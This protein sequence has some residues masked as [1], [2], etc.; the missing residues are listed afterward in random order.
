[1][2]NI[3]RDFDINY[4]FK[5]LKNHNLGKCKLFFDGQISFSK[6]KEFKYLMNSWDVSQ[7]KPKIK[8][9]GQVL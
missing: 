2:G 7:K 9:D 6:K 4:F 5:F 8:V 1:M 3:P